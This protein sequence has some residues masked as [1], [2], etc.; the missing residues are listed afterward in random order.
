[1]LVV[2]P[3]NALNANLLKTSTANFTRAQ[4]SLIARNAAMNS[5][6]FDPSALLY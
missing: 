3:A 4:A 2:S 5:G 6:G 1:M